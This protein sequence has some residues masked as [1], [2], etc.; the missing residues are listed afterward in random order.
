MPLNKLPF[1]LSDAGHIKSAYDS[2]ADEIRS[3]SHDLVKAIDRYLDNHEDEDGTALEIRDYAV[4]VIN[5]CVGHTDFTTYLV[6]HHMRHQDKKGKAAWMTVTSR[7]TIEISPSNMR[8]EAL[9]S[10]QDFTKKQKHSYRF[11]NCFQMMKDLG[12]ITSP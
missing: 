8:K 7:D 5:S 10:Y 6:R 12:V 4:G 9:P 1:K 3:R 11:G 2:Q